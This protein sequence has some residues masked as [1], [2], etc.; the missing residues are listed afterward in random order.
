MI[1]KI[2]DTNKENST[3]QCLKT[4]AAKKRRLRNSRRL[5]D[6]LIITNCFLVVFITDDTA[7][8]LLIFIQLM[9]VGITWRLLKHE[10]RN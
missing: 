6:F 5:C 2:T 4:A 7:L 10:N 1:I 9:L 8:V 3:G